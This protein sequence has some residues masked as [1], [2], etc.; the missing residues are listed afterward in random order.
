MNHSEGSGLQHEVEAERGLVGL[1]RV[2]PVFCRPQGDDE[3]GEA[4]QAEGSAHVEDTEGGVGAARHLLGEVPRQHGEA[5][6]GGGARGGDHG[7]QDI[8]RHRE[9]EQQREL[10]GHGQSERAG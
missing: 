5:E 9:A 10:G 1:G 8:G 4:L 7:E 3:A 6:H 2:V